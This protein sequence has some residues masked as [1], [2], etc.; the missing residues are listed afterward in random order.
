MRPGS[1]L[2]AVLLAA[3][4]ALFPPIGPG[5]AASEREAPDRVPD[6]ALLLDRAEAGR[7]PRLSEL[8]PGPLLVL[9][10]FTHCRSTCGLMVRRL[11]AAWGESGPAEA[12]A[13]VLVVSFD[14]QDTP[15]DLARFR[16]LYG[17]PA[18]WELAALEREEGLRFFTSLG[19]QWLTLQNR[20]FDHAGKLFVLTGDGRRSAVLGADQLTGERLA[21]E[22]DAAAHG[23]SLARQIGTHWIGFFGVGIVLLGLT[24][25]LSW[26]HLRGPRPCPAAR[27]GP[28]SGPTFP[29]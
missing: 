3:C 7:A 24:A 5:P 29:S 1:R 15:G 2:G 27:F 4:A 18:A 28:G 19:F 17:L 26:D 25:A 16:T 14:P 13:R 9:P 8:G 21:A 6:V 20:Q 22:L 12:R 10:V 11:Q 23:P